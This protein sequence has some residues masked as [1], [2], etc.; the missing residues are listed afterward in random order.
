MTDNRP[1][2]KNLTVPDVEHDI[3]GMDTVSDRLG[4]GRFDS[5]QTIG[6]HRVED[7]DH[8]PIAIV[9]AGELASDPLDRG[10][11]H[12]VLEGRTVAQGAGFA[13]Q[14]W[15]IV[16]G[17]IGRLAA[18]KGSRM[19]SNNAP[20]LA[21]H[22]AVGISLDL[23]RTSNR[24]GYDRV[25][26]VVEAHQTGLRDRRRHGM[27]A[28]ESTRIGNELGS[29]GFEHLPDRLISEFR[30]AMR[31]RVGD[32]FIEQPGVQLVQV[33]EPQP[34]REEA[35]SDQPNLVLDLPLLPARGWRTGNRVDQVVAAH[36]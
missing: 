16:P 23:D 12:P 25:F 18:S 5:R 2:T 19:L 30:M 34:R 22:D 36:L 6:Q 7:I 14:H 4:T 9:G 3:S 33:F 8:L 31:L 21:D 15:H 11:Q 35:F 24:A 1:H 20:I 32:T 28:I 27:E 13:S 17:I 26:V 29:F 10:R